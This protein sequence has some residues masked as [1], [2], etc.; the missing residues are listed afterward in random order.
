MGARRRGDLAVVAR[1]EGRCGIG[2]THHV[3]CIGGF[4]AE[5]EDDPMRE[6]DVAED[7]QVDIAEPRSDQGV[8]THIA[9]GTA[10]ANAPGFAWS[11][12]GERCRIEP[13]RQHTINGANPAAVRIEGGA[14]AGNPIG[15]VRIRAVEVIVGSCGYRKRRAASQID[16]RRDLPTV[17]TLASGTCSIGGSSQCSIWRRSPRCWSG[18]HPWALFLLEATADCAPK[19]YWRR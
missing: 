5:L 13:R 8:A 1:R 14:N 6:G 9:I 18:R 10:G 15:A 12:S 4:S 2:E 17:L 3:E 16:N 7:S 19:N 11:V